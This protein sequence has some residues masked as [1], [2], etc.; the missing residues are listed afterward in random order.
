MRGLTALMEA[1]MASDR[2]RLHDALVALGGRADVAYDREATWRLLHAFFGPLLRDEVLAFDV[3]AEVTLRQ[4]LWSAW[5][6]RRLVTSGE[7]LFLL[8]TFVGLSS[9]LARLGARS[10]WRRRL[11]TVI[12]AA[13]HP[14]EAAARP[15]V[16]SAAQVPATKGVSGSTTSDRQS[17]GQREEPSAQQSARKAA[18]VRDAWDVILVESG[19]SPIAL[20]RALRELLGQDLRD[21]EA[22]VD[23]PPEMLRTAVSRADAEALRQ[24]LAG[25]GARVEVRR[26]SAPA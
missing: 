16:G 23:H 9:V 7:L 13:A 14:I 5:K 2:R 12:E 25:V 21:L 20:I 18:R 8:R 1:L 3:N 11:A 17:E 22:I 6:A 4:L 15:A 10:N 26:A 19:S 24:R